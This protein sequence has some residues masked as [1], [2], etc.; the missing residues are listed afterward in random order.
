MDACKEN[1]S[2]SSWCVN[3]GQVDGGGGGVNKAFLISSFGRVFRKGVPDW[4]FHGEVRGGIL[5]EF[6]K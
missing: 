1:S 2:Q 6:C 5:F 3:Q 4:A